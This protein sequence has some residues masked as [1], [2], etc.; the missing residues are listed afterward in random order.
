MYK[1]SSSSPYVTATHCHARKMLALTEGVKQKVRTSEMGSNLV[2]PRL[3]ASMR[4][5][6]WCSSVPLDFLGLFSVALAEEALYCTMDT[7]PPTAGTATMTTSGASER[8]SRRRFRSAPTRHAA[9][10]SQFS[11]SRSPRNLSTAVYSNQDSG[12]PME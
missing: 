7:A 4:E 6:G 3:A 5:V 12:R 11:Q 2:S 10:T 1:R 9:G 8:S